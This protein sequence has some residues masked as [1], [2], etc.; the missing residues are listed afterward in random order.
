LILLPRIRQELSQGKKLKFQLYMALK[1]SLYKPAAFYKVPIAFASEYIADVFSEGEEVHKT[2]DRHRDRD[3]HLLSIKME[4]VFLYVIL[5]Y[6][7]C[8]LPAKGILLPLAES[9]TCT[10]REAAIVGS[11]VTKVLSCLHRPQAHDVLC[12]SFLLFDSMGLSL[13]V[14]AGLHSRST[15]GRGTVEARRDAVLGCQLLVHPRPDR[16]EVTLIVFEK[17]YACSTLTCPG[18]RCQ[19]G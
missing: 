10:L 8:C 9:G 19:C 16:E 17:Q 15:L 18:T 7:F 11:V 12:A 4:S 3:N 6:S 13:T 14:R 2:R 1:K 5:F